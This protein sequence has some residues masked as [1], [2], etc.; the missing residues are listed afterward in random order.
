ML[1]GAML[2]HRGLH[3]GLRVEWYGH[4]AFFFSYEEQ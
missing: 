3:I 4:D 2:A 1:R